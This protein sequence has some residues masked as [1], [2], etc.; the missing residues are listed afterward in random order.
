MR[1]K[2]IPK[3]SLWGFF[4]SP[5]SPQ[6]DTQKRLFQ[7]DQAPCK[8]Q[9]TRAYRIEF[10]AS[11]ELM[12]S[13]KRFRIFL[14]AISIAG[15]L[16]VW[17]AT[18]HYGPGLSTD[19]ARYL[20]TAE[21]IARGQGVIDYLGLPL[22]NWP[23][24]YPIILAAFNH[25]TGLDVFVIG[26]ILNILAFGAIVWLGG[27]FFE[28]SLPKNYTFAV[29]ASL[30]LVTSLPLIEVSANIASD[31]L[32]MVCV[33]L[34]LLA[35]QNYMQS[36][37]RRAWWLMALLAIVACFLRYAGLALVGSGALIVLLSPPSLR[38]RRS[39]PK[40]SPRKKPGIAA[41]LGLASPQTARKAGKRLLEAAAF[42]LLTAAPIAAWAVFHNYRLTGSVL[43][44]HLPSYPWG[45]FVAWVE[46]TA[47]WFMPQSILNIAPPLALTALLL[48]GLAARSS[49]TRWQAWLRRVQ[50]AAILPTLIF[51]VIYGLMLI[52]AISYPEHRVAG[53]QRIHAVILPALLVLAAVTAQEF[54]PRLPRKPR[55]LR[56]LALGFFALWLLFPLYRVGV[57]VRAS[58]ENGDVSYYNLYNTRTLRE[59]DIVAQIQEMQLSAGEKVYSN[60]EGAAWFYL[61]RRIY[62]LPRFDPEVDSSLESVMRAFDGWPA[63]DE[64]ATL[65]WFKRD[66]DY[67]ELVPTPDEM[68][69]FIS[70][71]PTF[72]G[73]YGI[74][75]LMDVN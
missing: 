44:A 65:V 45:L 7:D 10:R 58:M 73:R 2:V 1:E 68:Q 28:R 30:I 38:D 6:K 48:L 12:S 52:F 39:R 70:L 15:S 11:N 66:L 3:T 50:D 27:I 20:S 47:S 43:G 37:S 18:S 72:T 35:A 25:L 51:F 60:N 19:G 21:N 55:F 63:A 53:S 29:I 24:L 17:L 42:G 75:Y 41:I 26:Q 40:Q 36:H 64:T 5:S 23:P 34:F 56:S 13:Q 49:R 8:N 57:Y 67:K 33:L 31:P 22:I 59:S 16:L 32:F 14:P 62:R 54:L 71:R 46:K 61:R 4:G 9:V 69:A 74:I